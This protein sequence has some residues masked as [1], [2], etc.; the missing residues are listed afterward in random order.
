MVKISELLQMETWC[1]YIDMYI[2]LSAL[3]MLHKIPRCV[4]DN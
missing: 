3:L 2:E 1:S 4:V